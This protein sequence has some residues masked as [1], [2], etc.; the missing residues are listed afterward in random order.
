[1]RSAADRIALAR[2][3]MGEA[4]TAAELLY[5]MP[6]IRSVAGDGAGAGVETAGCGALLVELKVSHQFQCGRSCSFQGSQSRPV[7]FT[8]K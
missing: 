3:S 7:F 5:G 2:R 4:V 8:L 1:V 6:L